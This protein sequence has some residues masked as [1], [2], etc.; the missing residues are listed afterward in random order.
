[1][2]KWIKDNL[3][4]VYENE[5]KFISFNNQRGN[6]CYIKYDIFIS[7]FGDKIPNKN[8]MLDK[9]PTEQWD[10]IINYWDELGRFE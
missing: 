9:S 8:G 3:N 10:K 6:K 5:E 4:V 2:E 7:M 1:M